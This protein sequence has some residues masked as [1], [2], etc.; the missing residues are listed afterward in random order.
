MHTITRTDSE[1]PAFRTLVELLD[2]DLSIRDGD[3]HSFY[4]QFNKIDMI[5][6]AVVLYDNDKAIGCGAFKPYDDITVEVKRMFVLP[7]YRG[8]GIGL[9]IL[10]ALEQWAA[11]LGYKACI[12]ETGKKQPEAIQLYR[13]AGYATIPNYGQYENIDNSVCMKKQL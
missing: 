12:L 7:E 5:R 13:K 9:A 8:K 6:N 11:E 4:A 2:K 1:N 3:E 10:T